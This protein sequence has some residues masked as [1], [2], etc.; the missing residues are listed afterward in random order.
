MNNII[1]IAALS[2][3][4]FTA[5]SEQ[6][7]RI[8]CDEEQVILD[9]LGLNDSYVNVKWFLYSI[10]LNEK[11]AAWNDKKNLYVCPNNKKY[12][13]ELLL[14]NHTICLE[15]IEIAKD[16]IIFNI[17]FN[18]DTL[19]CVLTK[20]E[21]EGGEIRKKS[22]AEKV[23]IYKKTNDIMYYSTGDEIHKKYALVGDEDIPHSLLSK[24]TK[25]ELD[26]R[27]INYIRQNPNQI[28]KWLLEESKKRE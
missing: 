12:T 21:G 17:K 26:D 20:Y 13:N 15:S 23:A 28:P 27:L 8:E 11:C 16:T 1:I 6:N 5:C 7:Y 14:N 3:L 19:N 4:I 9:S 25:K 18:I 10:Y 22:L 24:G 2:I